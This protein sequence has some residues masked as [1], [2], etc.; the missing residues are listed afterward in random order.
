[1]ADNEEKTLTQEETELAGFPCSDSA[2]EDT[3]DVAPIEEVS[4]DE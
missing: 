2:G 1:M 4:V 3:P